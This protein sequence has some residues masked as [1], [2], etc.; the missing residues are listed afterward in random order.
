VLQVEVVAFDLPPRRCQ[1]EI[2]RMI[3]FNLNMKAQEQTQADGE[4][5]EAGSQEPEAGGWK[6]TAGGRRLEVKNWR[7]R[8]GGRDKPRQAS[9]AAPYSVDV[10]K[11]QAMTSEEEAAVLEG[12]ARTHI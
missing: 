12:R 2:G 4:K 6:S 5:P 9:S 10:W 7:P 3:K 1:L 11:Y 8:A